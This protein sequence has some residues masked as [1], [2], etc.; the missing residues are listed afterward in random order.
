MEK[1]DGKGRKGE[2]SMKRLTRKKRIS[3]P[4]HLEDF[5]SLLGECAK[6]GPLQPER[7]MPAKADSLTIDRSRSLL[8]HAIKSM[9]MLDNQSPVSLEEAREQVLK[10]HIQSSRFTEQRVKD[11]LHFQHP[12][13]TADQ[14]D[15]ECTRLVILYAR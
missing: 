6:S 15:E 5:E 7:N 1:E 10:V 2:Q 9:A 3:N 11:T 13:W 4:N 14:I 12:D 8:E